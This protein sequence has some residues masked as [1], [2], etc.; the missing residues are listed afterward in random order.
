MCLLDGVISIIFKEEFEFQMIDSLYYEAR[1]IRKAED[2]EEQSPLE[3]NVRALFVEEE[4]S[5]WN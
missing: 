2:K 4:N 5:D 1:I 3:I